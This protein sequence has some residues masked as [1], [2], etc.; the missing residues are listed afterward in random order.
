MHVLR[1]HLFIELVHSHVSQSAHRL[2][3]GEDAFRDAPLLAKKLQ[4]VVQ[5]LS[6]WRFAGMSL[7]DV[8]N[9]VLEHLARSSQ[10]HFRILAGNTD[11]EN[12]A[13]FRVSHR[14][15]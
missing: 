15:R 4:K 5:R 9:H 1:R 11:C 10:R 12:D 3:V 13:L 7:I 8:S 14:H 6:A 2:R